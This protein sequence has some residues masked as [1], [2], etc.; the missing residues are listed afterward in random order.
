MPLRI[1][2]M[3]LFYTAFLSVFSFYSMFS[4]CSSR[5]VNIVEI[6]FMYVCRMH[7]YKLQLYFYLDVNKKSEQVRHSPK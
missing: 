2:R 4:R 3:T 5:I 7:L 6:V 1:H